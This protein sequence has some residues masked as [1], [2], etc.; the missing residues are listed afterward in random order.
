M[1]R[2]LDEIFS[3]TWELMGPQEKSRF[4]A[5]FLAQWGFDRLHFLPMLLKEQGRPAELVETADY[6]YLRHWIAGQEVPKTLA[7]DF[8]INPTAQ[9]VRLESAGKHL[10]KRPGLYLLFQSSKGPKEHFLELSEARLL[11]RLRSD[12]RLSA[13][14]LT[15]DELKIL[16]KLLEQEIVLGD[17]GN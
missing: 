11:E 3:C 7:E 17:Q 16:K 8:E 5:D 14:E 12:V 6:E 13:D 15:K 9:F 2:R 10:G 1:S 4:Q